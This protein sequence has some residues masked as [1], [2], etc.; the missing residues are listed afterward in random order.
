MAEN[1]PWQV[2][3]HYG[4]S[5]MDGGIGGGALVSDRWVLTSGRN[6]FQ[7][8][9]RLGT[10]GQPNVFPEVYLGVR[11]RN[12]VQGGVKAEVEKASISSDMI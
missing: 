9:P 2:L 4:D 7:K 5:V 1:V 8:K 10:K 11:N 6:V 12:P 3:V